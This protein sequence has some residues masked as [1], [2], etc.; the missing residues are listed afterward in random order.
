MKA[1]D[2]V[3]DLDPHPEEVIKEHLSFSLIQ[4]ITVLRTPVIII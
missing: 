4:T 2:I 1:G 3:T